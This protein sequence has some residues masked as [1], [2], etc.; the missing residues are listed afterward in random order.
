[1]ASLPAP[2]RRGLRA[3]GPLFPLCLFAGALASSTAAAQDSG[4]RQWQVPASMEIIQ[5]GQGGQRVYLQIKQEGSNF[6][7]WAQYQTTQRNVIGNFSGTMVGDVFQTRILWTYSGQPSIGQYSGRVRAREGGLVNGKMLGYIFEGSTHDEYV[8]PA[9]YQYWSAYHFVCADPVQAPPSVEAPKPAV[10]LGRVGVRDASPPPAI[11]DAARSAKARNSPA[12]PGLER[13]CLASGGSMALPLTEASARIDSAALRPGV[14]APSTPPPE[15][16]PPEPATSVSAE[17][18][19]SLAA[20]GSTIADADPA[21]AE[22]RNGDTDTDFQFGFDVGSALFGDPALGGS[23]N[24]AI[25]PGALAIRAALGSV[26]Q[27]GFDASMNFH[28]QRH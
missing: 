12:A 21:V 8:K 20:T 11:C 2:I 28:F 3:R 10:A 26:G 5:N 25:G 27:A 9:Q 15:A 14:S 1:M 17:K 7:G 18:L 19:Q 22:A 6:H 23:G 4:C 24:T 16:S 13:Q